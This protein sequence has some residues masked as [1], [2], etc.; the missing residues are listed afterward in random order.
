MSAARQ[1]LKPTRG[2]ALAQLL[3]AAFE[4]MVRSVEHDLARKGHAGFTAANEF[5]LRAIH[6]GAGN[7]A[8]LARQLGVSRQAAAKSIVALEQLGYVER[9]D[10]PTDARRK[11]LQVT[12]R[13]Y[14]AHKL[15]AKLFEELRQQW[16]KTLGADRLAAL[17][18]TLGTIVAAATAPNDEAP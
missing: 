10:D 6:E 15:G 2:A 18:S 12:R 3:L 1:D 16:A 4:A 14:E 5:A 11:L 7:A 8:E 13:G 17:E 9:R